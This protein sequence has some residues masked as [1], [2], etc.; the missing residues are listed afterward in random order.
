MINRLKE[1]ARTIKRGIDEESVP[2]EKIFA[3]CDEEQTGVLNVQQFIN[4]LSAFGVEARKDEVKTI[5]EAI[6]PGRTHIE[7]EKVKTFISGSIF[8]KKDAA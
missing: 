6:S 3:E 5:F 1:I 2:F 4:F 8:M 7:L